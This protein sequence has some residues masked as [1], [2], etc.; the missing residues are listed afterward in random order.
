MIAA[1]EFVPDTYTVEE[2]QSL[3][4]TLELVGFPVNADVVLLLSSSSKCM[5]V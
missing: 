2:G 5:C 3:T 1:L 4:L